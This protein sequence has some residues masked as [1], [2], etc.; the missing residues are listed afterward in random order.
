MESL[1]TSKLDTSYVP[2][3]AEIRQIQS[4]LAPL[5]LEMA[6][7]DEQLAV[8]LQRREELET[9]IE[10]HQGF[11]SVSRRLPQDIL[12]EIFVA[13]LPT[14]RHCAAVVVEAPLL[15]THVC[16]SWRTIALALPRLWA[17]L[18]VSF[19]YFAGYTDRTHVLAE[20]LQ[21]SGSCGLALS[22]C[23]EFPPGSRIDYENVTE[24]HLELMI[25]ILADQ[26][27]RWQHL[28]L[29]NMLESTGHLL[30]AHPTPMLRSL[31]VEYWELPALEENKGLLQT[32]ESLSFPEFYLEGHDVWSMGINWAILTHLNVGRT[33][34]QDRD[35]AGL[36][37]VDALEILKLCT[38]L[39]DLRLQAPR[40]V[41]G[42]SWPML[43]EPLPELRTLL[44]T[45]ELHGEDITIDE[46]FWQRL[47]MLPNLERLA[48]YWADQ[49]SPQA[50]DDLLRKT[51]KLWWLSMTLRLEDPPNSDDEDDPTTSPP[52]ETTNTIHTF[53]ALLQC[54]GSG[55]V[56]PDLKT[57]CL[58]NCSIPLAPAL[59]DAFLTT[60]ITRFRHLEIAYNITD[61]DGDYGP[62][63][64]ER[65]D[66]YDECGVEFETSH[67]TNPGKYKHILSDDQVRAGAEGRRVI[68]F[69]GPDD[70]GDE[71]DE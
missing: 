19:S 7:L 66:Y 56:C 55:V 5:I 1:F 10:A 37:L 35:D 13:C 65:L 15:L 58:A 31:E 38:R 42:A 47:P 6:S 9:Y 33:H 16:S 8:L 68:P 34:N 27:H 46:S 44:I 50:V 29:H 28:Q 11:I 67:P 43:A 41:S 26:A 39:Q 69:A 12:E 40:A 36:T 45:Y 60:R 57:L 32:V 70:E 51:S 71:D 48:L 59:I 22:F 3:D 20:W 52:P 61:P 63:P 18:H 64:E 17:S 30:F 4:N 23:A 62:F 21:R 53:V 25:R 49:S 24:E 54:L 14:T 2:T